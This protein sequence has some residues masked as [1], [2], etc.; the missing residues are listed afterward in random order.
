MGKAMR[1][2]KKEIVKRTE[3][4]AR[5][6]ALKVARQEDRLFPMEHPNCGSRL[7]HDFET[8]IPGAP[9]ARLIFTMADQTWE[10]PLDDFTISVTPNGVT[11]KGKAKIFTMRPLPAPKPKKKAK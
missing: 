5:N 3:A 7:L 1:A 9:H 4:A 11:M 6:L 10:V 8:V 2:A